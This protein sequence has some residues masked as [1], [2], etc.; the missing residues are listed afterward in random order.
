[1]HK[2]VYGFKYINYLEEIRAEEKPRN[3]KIEITQN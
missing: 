2:L 3:W 1:M